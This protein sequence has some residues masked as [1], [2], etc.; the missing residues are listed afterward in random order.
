MLVNGIGFK[1]FCQKLTAFV[2]SALMLTACLSSQ[3]ASTS[4]TPEAFYTGIEGVS[5]ILNNL[6]FTDLGNIDENT[7]R[8]IY[9]TGALNI[10]KSYGRRTFGLNDPVQKDEA[11]A[12]AY[13]LA[14]RESEVQKTGESIN[15]S[16]PAGER[17]SDPLE[18]WQDGALWLAAR[19]GIISANDLNDALLQDQ[20]DLPQGSFNRNDPV[21]RQE[22]AAWLAKVL[23]LQPI[24]DQQKL[25]NSYRDWMRADPDK[26]PYIEAMLQ[27]DIMS[28]DDRGYFYPLQAVTR[29]Q[30]VEIARNASRYHLTSLKL[31]KTGTIEKITVKKDFSSEGPAD[32]KILD[33]RNSNGYLHRITLRIPAANSG[34]N[35][36][37]I[38]DTIAS[39]GE[40]DLVVLKG[41]VLG[42]SSLLKTGDR[43]EYILSQDNTVRFVYVFSSANE[44]RYLLARINGIDREN[45]KL[46]VTQISELEYPNVDLGTGSESFDIN[47]GQID[48]IYTY[49]NN[50]EVYEGDSRSDI[51]NIA[52]GITAILTVRGDNM[53]TGLKAVEL[54]LG[55]VQQGIVAGIV[56][57]NNP[58]L[59]YITLYNEDGTGISP[60]AR[61]QMLLR[62]TFIYY[63]TYGI[64]VLK[65]GQKAGIDDV[66]PGDSVFLQLDDDGYV[67]A[68]SAV[69]NYTVRY[70][71]VISKRPSGITVRFENGN[72]QVLSVDDSVIVVAD[73]RLSDYSNVK[74]G[75]RVKLILHITPRSTKVKEIVVE[76]SRHYM[77]GIYKGQVLYINPM[78]NTVVLQNLEA[79]DRGR[80]VKGGQNLF[81][82]IKL[83]DEYSLYFRGR[84]ISLKESDRLGGLNAYIAVQKDYGGEEKAVV[85]SFMNGYDAEVTYDD[86]VRSVAYG[87][88]EIRLFKENRSIKYDE[89]SIIIKDGRLVTGSSIEQSDTVYVSAVRDYSSSNFYAGV[90]QIEKRSGGSGFDIYRGRIR[91]I[92]E[93]RSFTVESF[94]RFE[95]NSWKYFNTPKTFNI[96]YDTRL[97]DENGVASMG[98][99]VGYGENSYLG[100][101]VYIV[102]SD[103]ES[104]VI[105]TAPFGP[106][107]T[108]VKG[109]VYEMAGGSTGEEGTVTEEP[110]ELKIYDTAVY[111]AARDE[112]KDGSEM[113]LSILKNSIILKDGRIIRPSEIKKGDRVKVYRKGSGSIGEAYIILVE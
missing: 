31:I 1:K 20:S 2:I 8:A 36:N 42:N 5:V 79:F 17:K 84:E 13:T 38:N 96:T 102:A 103:L 77:T 78:S 97:L 80:W 73:G 33:V 93:G 3:A 49:S 92:E 99:F 94:S 70:G 21:T 18:V 35:V 101:V 14:G 100:K 89:G 25:F 66:E 91:S 62:R 86:S 98:N 44:I 40:N 50:I 113:T 82:G 29:R 75:D 27:N 87:S 88:G 55:K 111:D 72:S 45:L 51:K 56:E 90:I 61:R 39:Q 104:V 23:K 60:Q 52:P 4:E 15:S 57:D 106:E 32:V 63:D 30:A 108:T 43:I 6:S 112:W 37:G 81:T 67:K 48:A 9:E 83:A 10:F 28:G 71:R 46:D 74:D 65:D 7:R 76:D 16:R 24:S 53:V 54:N 59:G 12:M 22:F 41:E 109:T 95:G 105:S 64:E 69:S 85:V 11:M 107:G 26:I 19:E 110:D 58:Q 68:I 34:M 47:S